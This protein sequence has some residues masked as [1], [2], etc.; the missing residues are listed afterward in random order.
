MARC[1]ALETMCID[2]LQPASGK[3]QNIDAHGFE[4][5]MLAQK[6]SVWQGLASSLRTAPSARAKLSKCGTYLRWFARPDKVSGEP[7]Y[8]LPI[9]T[10]H[11]RAQ[12][13]LPFQDGLPF[14]RAGQAWEI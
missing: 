8:E 3:L 12:V 2:V 7:Y 4:R 13:A 6:S 11:H 10:V 1:S 14:C 5:A 9:M